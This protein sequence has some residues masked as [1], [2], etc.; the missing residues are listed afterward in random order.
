MAFPWNRGDAQDQIAPAQM[1]DAGQE[2]VV[3]GK[4]KPRSERTNAEPVT[5]A[6]PKSWLGELAPVC[7]VLVYGH[8]C[9]RFLSTSS[10]S[11]PGFGR[12][13]SATKSSRWET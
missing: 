2:A 4:R 6:P 1:H 3:R 7:L 5:K 9:L 8:R 12:A 11:L 13:A 10:T